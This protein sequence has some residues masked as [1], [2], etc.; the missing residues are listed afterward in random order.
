MADDTGTCMNKEP[1]TSILLE[2]FCPDHFRQIKK[3]LIHVPISDVQL[4]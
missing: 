3:I 4:K 2:L 1:M